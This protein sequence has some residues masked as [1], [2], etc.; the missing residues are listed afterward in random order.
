[1]ADGPGEWVEKGEFVMPVLPAALKIDP[2]LAA[3][4]H[5]SAFLEL[6]ADDVVDPD[7]AV[8]GMEHVG[9]YLAQLPAEQIES[10]RAQI[11][12]VAAY[13]RKQKWCTDAVEYFDEFLNNVGIGSDDD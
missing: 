9:H 11:S 13:A 8:K 12:R 7:S 4:L 1:M 5:V 6:S 10:V 3:L 2:T